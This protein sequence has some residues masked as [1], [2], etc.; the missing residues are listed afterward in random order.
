M[1]M[2]LGP[3]IQKWKKKKKKKPAKIYI[4]KDYP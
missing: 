3:I 1:F 2:K 4:R